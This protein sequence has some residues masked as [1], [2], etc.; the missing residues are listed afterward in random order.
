MS[1]LRTA[2]VVTVEMKVYCHV[3]N[4]VNMLQ[5]GTL[6]YKRDNGMLSCSPPGCHRTKHYI[7]IMF[8]STVNSNECKTWAMELLGPSV[9]PV[10]SCN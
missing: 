10:F 3:E 5:R 7:T 8:G 2:P 9:S 4:L 6:S 1:P